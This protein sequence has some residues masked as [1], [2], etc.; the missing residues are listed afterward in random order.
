MRAKASCAT[1]THA[2]PWIGGG[3]RWVRA[4]DSH[5]HVYL[6]DH[7]Y[8]IETTTQKANELKETLKVYCVIRFDNT[9][10]KP[11]MLG[12]E[13]VREEDGSIPLSMKRHREARP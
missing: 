3:V 9:H 4:L 1:K 11:M 6:S 7:P 10:F 5:L 8:R 12:L 2:W 13:W